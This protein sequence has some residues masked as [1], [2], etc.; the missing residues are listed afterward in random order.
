MLSIIPLGA[1]SQ[2]VGIGRF[3]NTDVSFWFRFSVSQSLVSSTHHPPPALSLILSL[4]RSSLT[5]ERSLWC[6]W[7]LCVISKGWRL[8]IRLHFIISFSSTC[9]WYWRAHSPYGLRLR[10]AANGE[11]LLLLWAL[12]PCS[13]VRNLCCA[14]W[15]TGGVVLSEP[16][17][18]GLEWPLLSELQ[19]GRRQLRFCWHGMPVPA[20]RSVGI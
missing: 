15:K 20:R 16:S 10:D 4:P 11:V 9:T 12:F 2:P 5:A 19:N 6:S 13:Q 3:P 17:V 1:R 18:Q 7:Q 8:V 14:G